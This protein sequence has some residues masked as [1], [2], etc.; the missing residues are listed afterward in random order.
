MGDKCLQISGRPFRPPM[1]ERVI[2]SGGSRRS[3]PATG[4]VGPTGLTATSMPGWASAMGSRPAGGPCAQQKS[5]F[6]HHSHRQANRVNRPPRSP[7][8]YC[9]PGLVATPGRSASGGR[10]CPG[11]RRAVRAARGGPAAGPI[12]P[13]PAGRGSGPG[14]HH[15]FITMRR[16]FRDRRPCP[17][18]GSRL[19][20]RQPDHPPCIVRMDSIG[21]SHRCAPCSRPL[22]SYNRLD[23][24]HGRGFI[25]TCRAVGFFRQIWTSHHSQQTAV[26]SDAPLS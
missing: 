5:N 17:D 4:R 6:L 9:L 19:P 22:V 14:P 16:H 15:F 21:I 1:P 12:H 8:G 13:P 3:P 2:L 11:P 18:A 25:F 10:R 20:E 26:Y 7:P 23:T 24:V